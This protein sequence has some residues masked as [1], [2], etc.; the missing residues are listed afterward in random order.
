MA[1]D[2]YF[3]SLHLRLSSMRDLSRKTNRQNI[4][5]VKTVNCCSHEPSI[6]RRKI[7]KRKI[8]MAAPTASRAAPAILITNVPKATRQRKRSNGL[9]LW[10]MCRWSVKQPIRPLYQV[11]FAINQLICH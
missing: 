2:V 4:G 8:S 7:S 9:D 11:Q 6:G 3:S 1:F 5:Y 10:A